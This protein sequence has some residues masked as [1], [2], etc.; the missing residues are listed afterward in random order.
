RAARGV[1]GGA[2]IAPRHGHLPRR[3]RRH[4]G[5]RLLVS[6]RHGARRRRAC[7]PQRE[8]DARARAPERGL[9]RVGP[10]SR[11][12]HRLLSARRPAGRDRYVAWLP[13]AAL[14]GDRV[15][16]CATLEVTAGPDSA[17][18]RWPLSVS[19]VDLTFPTVVV[20]NDDTAHTGTTDSL[21][22]GKAVPGGTYNW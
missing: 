10:A 12:H 19:L 15:T 21:T 14:C 1:A 20:L 17:T 4:S 13:A 18:A 8:R 22:A 6:V 3:D 9:D 7:G 16:E 11:R 5:A 2:R